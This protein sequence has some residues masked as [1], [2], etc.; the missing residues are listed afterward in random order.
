MLVKRA[1]DD[2][3]HETQHLRVPSGVA[4][5]EIADVH[6]GME[7]HGPISE[8]MFVCLAGGSM[9]RQFFD[10]PVADDDSFS[11][12]RAMARQGYGCILIDHP[13]IGDSDQ[14]EDGFVLTPGL[15]AQI[16]A[17]V[18]RNL[19]RQYPALAST[20]TIGVG[21][22]MGAMITLLVQA[23]A[24]PHEGIVLLGFGF[25]G[26]PQYL[27][28]RARALLDDRGALDEAMADLAREM[29]R[30]PYPGVFGG[31]RRSGGDLYF[32]ANADP[33]ALPAIKAVTTHLLAM[34]AFASM[35]PHHWDAEA[36]RIK[37][38]VLLA[39]GD[40]DLVKPPDNVAQVFAASPAAELMVLP[41]TG[42][43]QFLFASRTALF[44][45]IGQW[46]AQFRQGE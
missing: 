1:P 13:G 18:L 14:P 30:V 41:E 5:G 39:L 37:V 4:V 44:A 34:P 35:L 46:A 8:P 10:L 23:A 20:R 40:Q 25:D 26:L 43:S 15:I 16:H 11:F 9:R 29:F 32:A 6:L 24:S 42:H 3:V 31:G 45:K 12:V 27:S 2:A 19:R 38:P 28:P 7:I 22:S 33:A 17:G 36:A 21:H